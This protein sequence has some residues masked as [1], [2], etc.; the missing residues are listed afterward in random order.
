MK[1]IVVFEM[2]GEMM[3]VDKIWSDE[4]S[5]D[6]LFGGGLVDS[7]LVCIAR[8]LAVKLIHDF[9]R[10]GGVLLEYEAVLD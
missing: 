9:S 4:K 10:R 1:S 6:T 3:C 2:E 8:K 7:S 5:S